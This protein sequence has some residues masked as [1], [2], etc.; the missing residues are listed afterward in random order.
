MKKL[1]F[2]A[3][4][5]IIGALSSFF[6][7][8]SNQIYQNLILPDF[9]P[10]GE[11]FPIVWLILYTLMGISSY[12]VYN[13]GL[14]T[15]EK[16]L[17]VYLLSLFLNFCWSIIFFKFNLYIVAFAWLIILLGVVIYMSKL[18]YFES[19]LAGLLQIPY[20]LWLIFAGLLNLAIIFLNF[21]IH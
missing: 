9:A 20:I 14:K 15:G 8:N 19:K 2:I 3:L 18:F 21:D 6:S 17:K 4:P 13:T 10:K 7:Q 11:I 12:L 5:I 16:A 1:Y